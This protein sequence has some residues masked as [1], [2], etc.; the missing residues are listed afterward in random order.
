MMIKLNK[1]EFDH[2]E[3]TRRKL[4]SFIL[5]N[6]DFDGWSSGALN[7]AIND[8]GVDVGLAAQAAPRG[9][10]DLAVAFHRQGDE[11]ML[12]T[13]EATD[14]T[15]LRYS[16]KVAQMVRF[17]IEASKVH[18][19]AVRRSITLFA[20]PS[21]FNEGGKLIWNTVDCM[22]NALEDTSTDSNWYTKRATLS[23][24]YSSTILFWL[25]DESLGSKDT[26]DFL[27]R[28]IK[29]VMAFEKTKAK[30]KETPFG[31]SIEGV[32]KYLKKPSD[33]HK[34]TFPGYRR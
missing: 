11:L 7:S 10:I 28:R 29:N 33:E 34:L 8:S 20:L 31:Q 21:N 27:D 24:V 12:I 19:E 2:I 4:V 25:G 3:A 13:L 5:P 23:A 16:E 6:V 17:R 18:K 30:I 22:W 1:T 26:W 9:A 32:L 14:I 15:N